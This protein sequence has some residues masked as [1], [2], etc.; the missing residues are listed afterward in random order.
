[1]LRVPARKVRVTTGFC[2]VVDTREDF[3]GETNVD[4]VDNDIDECHPV[5][6]VGAIRVGSP[7]IATLSPAKPIT[8]TGVVNITG[9]T[10]RNSSE[11]CL[12]NAIA[13][14]VFAGRIERNRIIDFVRPCAAQTPATC[15]RRSGWGCGSR[16]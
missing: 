11:Y 8:A 7:S 9:N 4:I 15:R 2:I 10:I 1:M 16:A 3:G 12:N 14:N 6:R 13:Y 5:A